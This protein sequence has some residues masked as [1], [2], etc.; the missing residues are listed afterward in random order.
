MCVGGGG[1]GVGVIGGG[2]GGGVTVF[3]LVITLGLTAVT[4]ATLTVG[5][6]FGKG[7]ISYIGL[8]SGFTSAIGF[9]FALI[10]NCIFIPRYSYLAA[11]LIK[12]LTELVILLQ[13]MYSVRKCWRGRLNPVCYVV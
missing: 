12:G 5:V 4:C 10:A 7:V 3:N 11:S 2:G 9:V 1:G 8:S 6:T 13:L